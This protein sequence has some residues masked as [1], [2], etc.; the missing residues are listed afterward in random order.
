[1]AIEFYL[2][3]ILEP[4]LEVYKEEYKLDEFR[5]L[6]SNKIISYFC[7]N[8]YNEL[9]FN[10]P[11]KLKAKKICVKTREPDENFIAKTMGISKVVS[12]NAFLDRENI[13]FMVNRKAFV[14]PLND[15]DKY[16]KEV[17]TYYY[18][19]EVVLV[20]TQTLS[21]FL[22]PRYWEELD[23]YVPYNNFNLI[24]ELVVLGILD[25]DFIRLW[26]DNIVFKTLKI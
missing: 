15:S 1:M 23:N 10:H 3:R 21:G 7:E 6:V 5:D 14:V 2:E 16:F 11:I 24:R 26:K 19:Y 25:N 18:I 22:L 4:R 12:F 20:L 13:M 17:K 8:E 9:P